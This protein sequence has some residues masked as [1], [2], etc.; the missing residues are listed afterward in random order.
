MPPTG[1]TFW[2]V[3]PMAS[4]ARG[5]DRFAEPGGIGYDGR[6]MADPSAAP[7]SVF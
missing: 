2:R 7:F 6:A 4:A 5:G 1:T 3:E